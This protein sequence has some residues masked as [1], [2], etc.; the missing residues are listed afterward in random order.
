MIF[1]L[2]I[3]PSNFS[4]FYGFVKNGKISS[5]VQDGIRT[6]ILTLGKDFKFFGVHIV[7][8]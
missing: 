5:S 6:D 2:V 3:S 1:I 8:G 7:T 4:L